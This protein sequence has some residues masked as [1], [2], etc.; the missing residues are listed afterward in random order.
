MDFPG[1]QWFK[2]HLPMQGAGVWSLVWEDPTCRGAATEPMGCSYGKTAHLEPH[3]PQWEKPLLKE[4]PEQ[5]TID[6]IN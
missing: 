4:D 3:A 6:K 5:P 2:I 1:V